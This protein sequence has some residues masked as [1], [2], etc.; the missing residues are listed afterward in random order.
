MNNHSIYWIKKFCLSCLSLLI[1]NSSKTQSCTTKL[2]TNTFV[3]PGYGVNDFFIPATQNYYITGGRVSNKLGLMCIN[4]NGDTLW[5]KLLDL[6]KIG[7]EGE[8]IANGIADSSGTVL[9][10]LFADFLATIDT[11]GN[12]IRTKE[13]ISGHYPSLFLKSL[14]RADDGD[15]VILYGNGGYIA[16]PVWLVKMSPDVKTIRWAKYIDEP[17]SFNAAISNMLIDG[18]NLIL[19]GLASNGNVPSPIGVLLKF[20]TSTGQYLYSKSY[21]IND[22]NGAFIGLHKYKGGYISRATLY[23]SSTAYLYDNHAMMR[24]DTALNVINTYKF[25]NMNNRHFLTLNVQSDGSY[26]GVNTL[27]SDEH[28]FVDANDSII[29]GIQNTTSTLFRN[30]DIV[31][32]DTSFQYVVS[33]SDYYLNG[34]TN[35]QFSWVI[36]KKDRLGKI[37][38]GINGTCSNTR[39][40]SIGK[41]VLTAAAAPISPFTIVD[42]MVYI[43]DSFLIAQP[44]PINITKG[45]SNTIVC[46]KLQII[47]STSVCSAPQFILTGRKNTECTLPIEWQIIQGPVQQKTVLND[48]TAIFDCAISGTYKIAARLTNTCTTITDTITVQVTQT[49]NFYLGNDTT[50][51]PG[52]SISL[53]VSGM[54]HNY[55]WSNGLNTSNI[56]VS[57]SGKYWACA[58]DY[59]N[60]LRSDTIMIAYYQKNKLLTLSDT[61]KCPYDTL[62]LGFANNFT[63]ISWQ[64]NT[65]IVATPNAINIFNKQTTTFLFSSKDSNS[66]IIIDTLNVNVKP[67]PFINLGNDTTICNRDSIRLVAPMGMKSYLWNT[68]STNQS[69]L[70]NNK[71]QYSVRITAPNSCSAIDSVIINIQSLPLI[72][73]G[74]DTSICNN[75]SITFKAPIAPNYT[76]LWSDGTTTPSLTT[77]SIGTYY[78]S[79]KDQYHC[80]SSDT[81]KVL[82]IYPTPILFLPADTAICPGF[83]YNLKPNNTFLSYFW[84]NGSTNASITISKPDTYTLSVEDEHHCKGVS[85]I[86]IAQKQNCPEA[87]FFPN[88]FTPNNDGLNDT[89]KPKYWGPLSDYHLKIYDRYGS[90]IF[91]TSLPNIG[92]NGKLKGLLQNIGAYVWVCNYQFANSTPVFLKGTLLLV[93]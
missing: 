80:T 17:N 51:C 3:Y 5:S 66:C 38:A 54:Y 2:Y 65:N 56:K 12:I 32:I 73:L 47:G 81:V 92:W 23:M 53:K 30:N 22:E 77:R 58:Y 25:S 48:S 64:P 52:D 15:L 90:I 45:C 4:Q 83:V 21:K 57:S 78:V 82:N 63:N 7:A 69:I 27:T 14:L 62:V 89:F 10:S 20:K 42:T 26:Y 60:Q 29:S 88:A 39:G 72:N 24:L 37:A 13:I 93:R 50:L 55:L 67:V 70:V 44:F 87:I 85:S 84:S 35:G 33:S 8:A 86:T 71:G 79:I 9:I 34:E 46:N 43:K 36:A 74:P 1:I 11:S 41:I 28:F 40:L 19:A 59:C 61:S 76:Y 18:D 75:S 68:G 31:L 91:E 16:G 49:S 6:P